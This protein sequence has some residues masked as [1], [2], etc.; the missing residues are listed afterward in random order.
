MNLFG[1]RRG[2][3]AF[4]YALCCA[5]NDNQL[6]MQSIHR[7]RTRLVNTHTRLINQLQAILLERGI[8]APHGKHKLEEM[9]PEILEDADN[10]LAARGWELCVE[11]L[12]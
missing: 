12:E 7:V 5:K 11:L 6:T 1:L 3:P 2:L 4:H 9:L 10:S 8:T